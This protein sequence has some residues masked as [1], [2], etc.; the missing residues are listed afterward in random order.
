MEDARRNLTSEPVRLWLIC[1]H[2]YSAI[3]VDRAQHVGVSFFDHRIHVG[4]ANKTSG[5]ESL[6]CGHDASS[7]AT[8]DHQAG[9]ER[10]SP[11]EDF[12]QTAIGQVSL[13]SVIGVHHQ[14]RLPF[15]DLLLG[16]FP[17]EH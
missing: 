8:T 6:G 4:S 16:T 10:A 9:N 13:G 14:S 12:H 15:A 11:I 5:P 2:T 7:N 1:P 17:S 3:R